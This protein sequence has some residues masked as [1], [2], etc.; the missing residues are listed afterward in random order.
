[1]DTN[2]LN[3][4]LEQISESALGAIREMVSGKQS[5]SVDSLLKHLNT[6][7]KLI[8][9]IAEFSDQETNDHEASSQISI[10]AEDLK[11][12]LLIFKNQKDS[13]LK[14]HDT[15]ERKLGDTEEFYQRSLLFL[16]GMFGSE[17]NQPLQDSIGQIKNLIKEGTSSTQLADVFQRFKDTALRE[18]IKVDAG[19]IKKSNPFSFF[20]KLLKSD[21]P[22]IDEKDFNK[23]YLTHLKDSYRNITEELKLN[24]GN[25]YSKKLD[26][27]ETL[28]S[29]SN[30]IEELHDIR[31]TILSLIT[32]YIDRIGMERRQAVE[33]LQEIGKRLLNIEETILKSLADTEADYRSNTH[34]I[35][36]LGKNITEL[37]GKVNFSKT[38]EEVKAVFTEKLTD[39]E[40]AIHVKSET[41]NKNRST[42]KKNI[43]N[44]KSNLQEMRK[45]FNAALEH[46]QQLEQ[47]MLTD[48]LTGAYNRRAYDR[49]VKEEMERYQR[50]KQPL[51]M[52]LLDIDHFKQ[53]NDTYGHAIGDKCLIEIVQKVKA[54]IRNCDFLGRYGGEEFAVILPE[55]NSE[56]AR[57]VAEKLRMAVEKTT[58]LH[59]DETVKITISTGVT[60]ATPSDKDHSTLFDRMDKAMYEA[61]ASGRNKVVVR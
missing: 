59:K 4:L 41:D 7:Q 40:E 56:S 52:L 20:S 12:K 8:A 34:F 47:E 28:I 11:A 39:I 19:E 58:F 18:K 53:V 27:I 60:G 45:D 3:N 33:V 61:K 31:G 35:D 30:N 44:L 5:L 43:E 48:P 25:K 29:E 15:L 38:L 55:T 6:D 37:K 50:Y 1:M 16:I 57:L 21:L 23:K 32:E 26:R 22:D 49:R 14:D 24:L 54:N 17:E 46:S 2:Q 10:E 51:S 42:I 36:I 13:L 9:Q